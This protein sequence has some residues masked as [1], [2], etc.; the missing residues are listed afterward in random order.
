LSKAAASITC[1]KVKTQRLKSPLLIATLIAIGFLLDKGAIETKKLADDNFQSRRD[2]SPL[3]HP[4]ARLISQTKNHPR[5]FTHV[6]LT[7]IDTIKTNM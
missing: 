4:T 3:L 6:L 7:T 1:L 2:Q 5:Q